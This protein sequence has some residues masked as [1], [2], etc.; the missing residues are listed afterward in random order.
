VSLRLYDYGPSANCYKVRLLLAQLGREY[1]RIP[2]DIFAGETLT[3]EYALINPARST[4]VL[5]VDGERITESNAILVFLADGTALMPTAPIDRARVIAWLI[6]EQTD[7]VATMGGLRFRLH[8]GRLKAD[9]PR[10]LRRTAGALQTLELL[11]LHLETRD[12]FVG[13]RYSIADIAI[14]GYA[15]VAD[16]ADLDIGAYPA[17]ERWLERVRAQPGYVNDLQPYPANS[18]PGAGRSIYD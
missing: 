11:D 17:F 18:H 10:A 7:V 8:T 4:P 16:E 14:F 12:F 6:F 2:V 5:E 9:D 15:H 3:P 13:E 1:E